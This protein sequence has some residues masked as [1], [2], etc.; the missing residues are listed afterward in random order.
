MFVFISFLLSILG[1]V[2][3]GFF[4][5]YV[6]RLRARQR[7]KWL[8][9]KEEA[10]ADYW[11]E[12]AAGPIFGGLFVNS[13]RGLQMIQEGEIERGVEAMT[14][15]AVRDFMRTVRYTA[16]GVQ[17]QRGDVLIEDLSPAQLI[18]QAVGLSPSAVNERYDANN[19][20]KRWEDAVLNRR[21]AL[22]DGLAMAIRYE[23]SLG[24]DRIMQQI[25]AFNRAT[26][27]LAIDMAT[28]RRSLQARARYTGRASDGIIVNPRIEA[29][30]RAQ[31][32]FAEA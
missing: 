24:R 5:F 29:K 18:M 26:P 32:R 17:T 21:A 15:K 28:I 11:L 8:Y 30:A 25:R 27:E 22:L 2:C 1:T 10:L 20:I 3:W 14:P 19:A 9:T 7:L 23:D 13:M 12:Q 16:D 6:M 4:F 31:G